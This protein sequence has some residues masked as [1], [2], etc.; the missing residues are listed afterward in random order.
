M[1]KKQKILTAVVLIL[2]TATLV[3]FPWSNSY[4]ALPLLNPFWIEPSPTLV[5]TS[6]AYSFHPDWKTAGIVWMWI[7]I[8]YVGL[9]FILK[10]PKPR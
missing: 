5:G 2:F 10:S 8:V 6:L 1:N 3:C 4:D 7:G 9:F